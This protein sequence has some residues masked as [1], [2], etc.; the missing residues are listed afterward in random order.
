MNNHLGLK[1][2]THRKHVKD[3]V[4]QDYIDQLSEDEKTWLSLFNNEY[5]KS[6]FPKGQ[7]HLHNSLELKRAVYAAKNSRNRDLYGIKNCVGMID[8]EN[9]VTEVGK[10]NT[11]DTLIE[12][13]DHLLKKSKPR[14]V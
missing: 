7:I 6:F 2:S 9:D 8:S 4:D 10:D 11:E 5:Y 14:K 12:L 13:L 3:F 1:K